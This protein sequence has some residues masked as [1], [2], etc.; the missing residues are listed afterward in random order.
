MFSAFLMVK[1]V[2][3]PFC[4]PYLMSFHGNPQRIPWPSVAIRGLSFLS[5]LLSDSRPFMA[6]SGE[7][8]GTKPWNPS[9]AYIVM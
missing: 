7:A 6:L 1:P 3:S 5:F 8:P 2:D 9:P 4:S